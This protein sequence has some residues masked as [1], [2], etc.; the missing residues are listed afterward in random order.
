[1]RAAVYTAA[2]GP[3][4]IQLRE[5][6]TPEAG[7]DQIR[8]RVRAAG[9][10]RADILQRRGRYP[11][12][13]GWPADIPG[14]EYAGEVEAVGHGVT[15]WHPGDRVMGLVGSGAH[16]EAVVVTQHEALPIPDN[17]SFS[18]AAAIPEVFLTAY[19]ALITRGRL[20]GGERVLVHAVGSGV[21]TAAVQLA[22]QLGAIVWGTS[23]TASKL[24]RARAYGLE[25]AID[26][27]VVRFPEAIG[28][29]ID[30]VLD[31]LGGPAF[32]DNLEVLAPRGRL[33]LLGSLAGTRATIDIMPILRKRLEV[34]GTVMR[35][36]G[37]DERI[38]LVHEFT[39]QVL[40]WFVQGVLHPVVGATYPMTDLAEA[41][42]AMERDE[43]FGK[44]VLVW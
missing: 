16:A 43:T 14:L 30:I 11:A 26:T 33:I 22:R 24:E 4:V 44:V 28:Q 38:P 29:P 19:D 15:R 13:P 40:P 3:E 2:G 8:V 35:A 1:M 31:M 6:A 41:H 10:N 20:Q 25:H 23:R 39:E 18:E 34:I 9:L 21:G 7:L 37:L 17:L 12:P 42:I 5:V 27:S 32:S 36:R